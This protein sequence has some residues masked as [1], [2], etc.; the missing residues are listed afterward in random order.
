MTLLHAIVALCNDHIDDTNDWYAWKKINEQRI[1]HGI[2]LP[3]GNQYIKNIDLKKKLHD[4]WY[5][6]TNLT[7]KGELIKYYITTWGGIHTNSR[8]TMQAYMTALPATLIQRGQNGVASWSKALVVHD[9]EQYAIFDARVSVGINSLQIINNVEQKFLY[10][11]LASRNNRIKAANHHIKARANM[12]SWGN[13]SENTFYKDYLNLL[14]HA[15]NAKNT[16]I[17]TVEMLLF[18]KAEILATEM[19]NLL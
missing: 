2:Q 17:S 18:S 10:P 19:I 7:R 6:E 5:N 12:E 11:I 16:N 8:E 3:A 4:H 9:P 13:I 1:P 14:T 15:A